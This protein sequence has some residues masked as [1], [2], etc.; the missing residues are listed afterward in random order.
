M[1]KFLSTEQTKYLSD[2]YI[3]SAFKYYSLIC[4]FYSKA[5]KNQ[6]Y[7]IHKPILDLMYEMGDES[8]EDLLLKVGL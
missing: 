1:K 8:F 5:A 7:K 4:K 3:M 2:A 6:I